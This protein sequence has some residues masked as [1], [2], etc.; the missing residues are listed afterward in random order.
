M[1]T[2]QRKQSIACACGSR[3]LT[4][5]DS[6]YLPKANVI[7]RTRRCPKCPRIT[8]TKEIV[9]NAERNSANLR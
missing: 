9:I 6:R 3:H 4:V 1:L 2:G 7:L 8:L 5:A